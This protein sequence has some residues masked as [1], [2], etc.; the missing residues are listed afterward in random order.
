MVGIN[1]KF[2]DTRKCLYRT[3]ND[4]VIIFLVPISFHISKNFLGVSFYIFF[5]V[6]YRFDARYFQKVYFS[7]S[8]C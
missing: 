7:P 4:P 2:I 6:F 8:I 3:E 5:K 1:T